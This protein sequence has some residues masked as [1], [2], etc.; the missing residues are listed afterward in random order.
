MAKKGLTSKGVEAARH[1]TGNGRPITKS[2]FDGL[3]L[4]VASGGT[5]SW[6]YRFTLNGRSREMGLGPLGEAPLGLSLAA[7]REAARAAKA[8]KMAGIDPIE[9]REAKRNAAAANKEAERLST[10]RSVAEGLLETKEAGWKNAKHKQQWRNTLQTY[11]YPIIGDL[12]VAD[13]SMDHVLRVLKPIW[14]QKPETASRVRGRIERVLSVAKTLH[15]RSGENPATW[16]GNLE[17]VLPKPTSIQGKL[18]EHHPALPWA[19]MPQFFAEL[20]SRDSIDAIALKV[21]ILTASRTSEVLEMRWR[22]LELEKKLWTVP[23]L[24]MKSKRDHRQPL[25]DETISLLKQ[26]RPLAR[27]QDSFVFPGKRTGKSLSQM[28][29]LMLL[30]RMNPQRTDGSF[31]WSDGQSGNPVT[32]HGMRS[33]FRDWAGEVTG[34][35]TDVIESQLAHKL[36]DKTEAAYARGDLLAKRAELVA[37]W[38]IYCRSKHSDRQASGDCQHNVW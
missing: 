36:R 26:L 32:V 13:V 24:R 29:L 37:A 28:A 30:R 34:F 9:H 14:S 4:Q 16:R 18:P 22:E 25:S 21:C 12:P 7:A 6:L 1:P 27:A 11:V 3:H 35:P 38:A 33:T 8:L 15:L 2:D 23:S 20:A 10:F 5:K 19:Q 17:N 31:R